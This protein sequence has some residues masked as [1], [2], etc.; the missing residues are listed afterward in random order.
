MIPLCILRGSND[1]IVRDERRTTGVLVY[2]SVESHELWGC[3]WLAACPSC[4]TLKV[5]KCDIANVICTLHF[6]I[7]DMR[8]FRPSRQSRGHKVPCTLAGGHKVP[9]LRKR[10]QQHKRACTRRH[11]YRASLQ[12]DGGGSGKPPPPLRRTGNEDSSEEP[13]RRR[14]LRNLFVFILLG[15]GTLTA[16]L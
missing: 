12:D 4:A 14:P 5:Y 10:V 15:V 8:S 16:Q 6:C 11:L 3:C 9:C 1:A 13:G 7:M 2:T